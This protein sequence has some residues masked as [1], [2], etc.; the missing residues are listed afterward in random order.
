MH[1]FEWGS[2]YIFVCILC[3]VLNEYKSILNRIT[4]SDEINFY[5]L[6]GVDA[7]H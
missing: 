7:D 1:N 2:L 6:W 4:K 3:L 5:K